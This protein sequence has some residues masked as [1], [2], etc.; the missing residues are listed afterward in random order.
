MQSENYL[1]KGFNYVTRDTLINKNFILNT[2]IKASNN[3]FTYLIECPPVAFLETFK[4]GANITGNKTFEFKDK[5]NRELILTPDVQAH[6]FNH[7][8]KTVDI[9][10]NVRYSWISPTFRY[11]NI[12]NRHFYQLGYASINYT[13]ENEFIELFICA[14]QFI[15]F[16]KQITSK[17]VNVSLL[18]PA[19][20]LEIL[21]CAFQNKLDASRLFEQIRN[22]RNE[23]VL[24]ILSK[25]LDES[26]HK[27]NLLNIFSNKLRDKVS[28][29]S[30]KEYN[31]FYNI[32]FFVDLL[33]TVSN[34]DIQIEIQNL[35]SSEILSGIGLI[36]KIEDDKIGDGG[37]YSGY[38]KKYDSKIKTA[39]S[40]CTGINA[41]NR[42]IEINS[43][44]VVSIFINNYE[45]NIIKTIII[46]D[47]LASW[48]FLL[49][50]Q[51]VANFNKKYFKESTWVLYIDSVESELFNGRISNRGTNFFQNFNN[52]SSEKIISLFTNLNN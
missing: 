52:Y 16:I 50:I 14:K 12:P 33:S 5:S 17:K 1:P 11:R 13:V 29:L 23:E 21:N 40:F 35:Y 31:E 30:L 36:I 15:N 24:L 2:F 44:H 48:G 3:L 27:T 4:R 38:G 28:L 6:I 18:N 9:N 41:L 43:N 45:E 10:K 20:I 46:S 47:A 19:L 42:H 32:L 26:Q 8:I 22:L 37:I 34:I 51:P 7:Y 49:N 39:I 25:S